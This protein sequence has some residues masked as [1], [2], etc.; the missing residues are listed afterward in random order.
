MTHRHP[1]RSEG[2]AFRWLP[3]VAAVAVF[4][5]A[6]SDCRKTTQPPGGE[7]SSLADSADQVIF[8][9]HALL[10][11]AGVKRGDMFADTIYVF[12]NQTLFA[13]RKVRAIFNT[14]TGAPN[15]TLKGDRGT[16]DLQ[17]QVLEGFGNVVVTS[18]DGKRLLSNHL[19]YAQGMNQIS[20]DSA[21]TFYRGQDVQRGIGFVSDP[22][23]T[24]FRCLRACSVAADVP[25]G[26]LTP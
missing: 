12:R 23:I 20:S 16:Y 13:L 26:N 2:S 15:G 10:T 1:E 21:F 24:V 5:I 22:N 25:L 8:D 7:A 6:A 17:A 18:T 9:G 19:K 14:E 3:R 4:A 11:T